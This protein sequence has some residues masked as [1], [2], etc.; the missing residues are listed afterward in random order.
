MSEDLADRVREILAGHPDLGEIRMFG[1]LCFTLCGNMAVG[2][3]KRGNLLVR[4]APGEMDAALGKPGAAPM[5]MGERV[6]KGFLEVD[7]AALD[8]AAL[9]DWISMASTYAGSLPPKEK[10]PART[11]RGKRA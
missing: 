4:V 2:I 7:A 11:S 9:R 5:A 8:D 3:M 1:G 6:M 10:K